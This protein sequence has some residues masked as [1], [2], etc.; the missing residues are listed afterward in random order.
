MTPVLGTFVNPIFSD[1][2][3]DD[4]YSKSKLKIKV[5]CCFGFCFILSSHIP[6]L[7]VFETRNRGGLCSTLY[8]IQ[9]GG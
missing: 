5:F 2:M 3:R 6:T 7:F 9:D 8:K 4:F 1:L